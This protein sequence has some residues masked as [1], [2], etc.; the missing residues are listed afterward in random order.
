MS[1]SSSLE[2]DCEQQ[3]AA[4]EVLL[5]QEDRDAGPYLALLASTLAA[6]GGGA[7]SADLALDLVLNQIVEQAR[8]ASTASSAAIALVSGEELIC[9]ATTGPNAPGLGVR[10]SAHTGLS[11]ACVETREP[12][13]CDDTETDPRV[14]TAAYRS[15]EIRS[16][17]MVPILSGDQLLGLFQIFSPRANEFGDREVQTLQAFSLRIVNNVRYVAETQL[18]AQAAGEAPEPSAEAERLEEPEFESHVAPALAEI[19]RAKP[20]RR[21]YWTSGLTGLVIA[22]ALVLGWMAGHAGRER[23]FGNAPSGVTQAVSPRASSAPESNSAPGQPAPAIAGVHERTDGAAAKLVAGSAKAE[24]IS[25]A[26]LVVYE[27]GK[28]IYR[29]VPAVG[30]PG[31]KSA[32]LRTLPAETVST[33]LIHRVEPQYP[34]GAQAS[35]IDGDVSM[36]V[37]VDGDGVVRDVKVQNGDPQLAPSAVEAVR[38]WRFTPYQVNGSNEEF[39]AQVVVHFKL[40]Q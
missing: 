8:L 29:A 12:Q 27:N 23:V 7:L 10:L 35:G 9:R 18:D 30:I 20:H 38:Q 19:A 26:G 15:L 16:I 39:Q 1:E 6:N 24:G 14:D 5:E 32:S 2:P 37:V 31:S 13:R 34:E 28:I 22:L 33:L 4:P 17:L 36:R 3:P 40:P 25:N 21:D 11:G